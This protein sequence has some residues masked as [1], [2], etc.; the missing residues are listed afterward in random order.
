MRDQGLRFRL[1]MHQLHGLG[2]VRQEIAIALPYRRRAPARAGIT[3][4]ASGGQRRGLGAE[5]KARGAA[6]GQ[7]VGRSGGHLGM[8]GVLV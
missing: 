1:L 3:Q 4:R 6:G 7:A 8:R 2:V 5:A